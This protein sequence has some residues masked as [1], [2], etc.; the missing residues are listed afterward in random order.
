MKL[1]KTLSLILAA[2]MTLALASCGGNTNGGGSGS[3]GSGSSGGNAAPVTFARLSV[4]P[5]ISDEP[6]TSPTFMLMCMCSSVFSTAATSRLT[7]T[8]LSIIGPPF[9]LELIQVES[10]HF[11]GIVE[12]IKAE[13][14]PFLARVENYLSPFIS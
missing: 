6:I 13:S 10:K 1:K 8:L 7:C 14:F 5:I 9:C 3:S 12:K 11:F 2:S 4:P